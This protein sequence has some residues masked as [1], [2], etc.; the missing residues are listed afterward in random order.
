MDRDINRGPAGFRRRP[1]AFQ[2][3]VEK[4]NIGARIRNCCWRIS[5]PTEYDKERFSRMKEDPVTAFEFLHWRDIRFVN[6]QLEDTQ[7]NLHIQG[8]LE[9]LKSKKFNIIKQILGGQY[10]TRV[11]LERRR[12]SAIQAKEYAEKEDTRVRGDSSFS[13]ESGRLSNQGRRNRKRKPSELDR[14]AQ[15]LKDGL[16]LEEIEDNHPGTFLQ[17][18][19][20]IVRKFID[21]KG[22]RDLRPNPNNIHIYVGPSGAGKDVTA[23]KLHPDAYN[24]VWPTGG[25]W[26]WPKYRGQDEI[27]AKEFRENLTYQQMLDLFDLHFMGTEYKGGNTQNVSKKIIITT[28]REPRSWYK[29]VE[30]KSELQRR[31]RE[32]ATIFDFPGEGTYPDF[33]KYERDELFSFD[34]YVPQTFTN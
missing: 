22:P 11:H 15:E 18:E 19:K 12:G 6:G 28:I 24:L 31:I 33:V 32:N 29:G 9:L 25:R 10:D 16:S 21:E 17:H 20:K 7:S 30:D 13:F 14:I 1:I 27:L 8:Y 2:H 3:H 34:R 4:L 5:N 26:W 23:K